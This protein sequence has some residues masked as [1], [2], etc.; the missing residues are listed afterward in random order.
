MVAMAGLLLTP[1]LERR[2][3]RR[4]R[5]H[6]RGRRAHALLGQAVPLAARAHDRP[7]ASPGTSTGCSP[8]APAKEIRLFGLGELFRDCYR[9]L[10]REL[11]RER[12]GAR[13]PPR[14]WPTAPAAPSPCWP[15]F[16]TFAYIA[17]QTITA[18]ITL[19]TMVMYYQAFQTGLT[20]LQ[21]V[22]GGLAGLYEDNLF[23]T[24]YHEFMALEPRV[25]TPAQPSPVPRPMREGVASRA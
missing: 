13:Q 1:A 8:T 9:D 5:R 6:P 11:R 14:S 18:S 4:G 12:I 23:L 17:W 25:L 10:R 2:P 19:G 24:Y 21:A 7:S 15:I 22:L 20:S 16:G 3:D